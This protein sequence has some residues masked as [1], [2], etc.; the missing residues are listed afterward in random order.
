MKLNH[1]SSK[2]WLIIGLGNPGK[3]YASTPHNLGYL[4]VQKL[5]ESNDLSF[6]S[7]RANSYIAQGRLG[8]GAN[9]T[10]G[11]SAILAM[12]KT[13]MNLCGGPV[14]ALVQYY[15]IDPGA[16]LL[17][18]HDDIDL[19]A[20]DL[21][22]KRGGGEGGHN[23]LRSI[24]AALGTRN[25]ARLRLGAGRPTNPDISPAEYV[26]SPF[27][28][29]QLAQWEDTI[30]QAAQ[31]VERLVNSDFISTQQFLHSPH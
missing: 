3:K 24:S 16:R 27:K 21:R 29:G 25:Y 14:N 12:S 1:A 19:P 6:K 7:H 11:G 31:T 23:G 15:R 17:V 22:L 2:T 26:L 28:T 9:G 13:Y 8:I 18:I 30:S 4:T 20:W 10:P 5:A